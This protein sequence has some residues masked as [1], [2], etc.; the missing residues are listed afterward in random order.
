L[1]R[2]KLEI[3]RLDDSG[4]AIHGQF[5]PPIIETSPSHLSIGMESFNK[6]EDYR[7][8]SNGFLASGTL[9]NTN[10]IE[11]FKAADKQALIDAEGQKVAEMEE[12]LLFAH[13][14]TH[15]SS[16]LCSLLFCLLPSCS[17]SHSFLPA[18]FLSCYSHISH[19]SLTHLHILTLHLTD[20]P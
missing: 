14:L 19:I 11:A 15:P 12:A 6:S 1:T 7:T 20:S 5:A 17:L 18:L 8:S 10:T 4:V 2:R 13:I 9:L 3:Y 16:H